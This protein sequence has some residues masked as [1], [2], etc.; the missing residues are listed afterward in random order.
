MSDKKIIN[1]PMAHRDSLTIPGTTPE[2]HRGIW[3]YDPIVFGDINVGDIV[4]FRTCSGMEVAAIGR[5]TSLATPEE[6]QKFCS[7][8]NDRG[9][10]W[11]EVLDDNTS[12]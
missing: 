5:V 10:H 2:A 3:F 12:T 8:L 4:E 9:F 7:K 11:E 6:N 1:V